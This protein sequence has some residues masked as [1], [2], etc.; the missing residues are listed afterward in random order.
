L[1]TYFVRTKFLSDPILFSGSALRPDLRKTW[2]NLE[3]NPLLNRTIALRELIDL[4]GTILDA[5]DPG[6][7]PSWDT[8]I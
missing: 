4:F 5:R 3:E 1:P 7:S 8:R 6:I 2:A